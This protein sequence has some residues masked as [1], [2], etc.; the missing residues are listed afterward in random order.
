[1]A[2]ASGAQ[3]SPETDLHN[4]NQEVG[5]AGSAGNE[6]RACANGCC[7]S[8]ALDAKSSQIMRQASVVNTALRA[9]GTRNNALPYGDP[10]ARI[11][12]NTHAK[13]VNRLMTTLNEYQQANR[14]HRDIMRERFAKKY[15]T[16]N[17][18]AT[19]EEV[20]HALNQQPDHFYTSEV[21]RCVHGDDDDAAAN[22]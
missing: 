10:T 9:M 20:A 12:I 8:R 14:V 5:I 17:P 13:L 4:F 2:E 16:V 22:G 11:R 15:R 7:I 21:G 6:K 18:L 3:V 1:M 19:D